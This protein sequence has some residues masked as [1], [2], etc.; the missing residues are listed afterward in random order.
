MQTRRRGAG[1]VTEWVTSDLHLGHRAI[2]DFYPDVRGHFS[3][4][5]HMDQAI[6]EDWNRQ[7]QAGDLVYMLGDISFHSVARSVEILNSLQ[8][9]KILIAG[10]HDQRNLQDPSFVACFQ[11]VHNYLEI[12]HRGH[13]ICMF[14]YPIWDWNKCHRGTI[15]LHGHTH[16]NC[17]SIPG[18]IIDV[19]YDA[20]RSVVSDLDSLVDRAL[21]IG[22]RR[23]Q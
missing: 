1:R 4:V 5:D 20:T 8:G 10:N 3:S 2:I 11:Q 7:V 16:G 22:Y 9:D 15:M 23:Y 13:L 19:G 12:Q 21:T 17:P 18:R 14:H 6:I